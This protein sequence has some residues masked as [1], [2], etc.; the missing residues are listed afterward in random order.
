ME[1]G[2]EIGTM[3]SVGRK[4]STSDSTTAGM[5]RQTLTQVSPGVARTEKTARTSTTM[6]RISKATRPPRE[7]SIAG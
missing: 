5:P 2:C 1:R 6:P 7:P 3:T 4:A